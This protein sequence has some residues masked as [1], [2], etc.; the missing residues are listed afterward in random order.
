MSA[1]PHIRQDGTIDGVL[2]RV[3]GKDEKVPVHLDDHGTIHRCNATREVA[4]LLAPHLYGE[5]LRV[6]GSGR[7]ERQPPAN[8]VLL[9]FDI[10]HFEPLD[11]RPLTEVVEQLQQ[12][13]G[14]GWREIGDPAAVLRRLREGASDTS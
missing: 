13:E 8:W 11:D 9:Q 1:H 5:P 10:T 12:T 6:H 7:W 2:I 3:G 14:S 4:R